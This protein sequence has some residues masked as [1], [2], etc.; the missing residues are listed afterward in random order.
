MTAREFVVQLD[1]VTTHDLPLWVVNA[2]KN[3]AERLT[4][5]DYDIDRITVTAT[6]TAN[7]DPEDVTP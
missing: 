5:G 4:T 6:C 1:H 7:P 2:I 3:G